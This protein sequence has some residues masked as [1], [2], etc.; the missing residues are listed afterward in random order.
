MTK[1]VSRRALPGIRV[2]LFRAFLDG[3]RHGIEVGA[4][5]R[6]REMNEAVARHSDRNAQ[7]ACEIQDL[8]L[9]GNVEAVHFLDNLVFNRFAHD[10]FNLGNDMAYVKAGLL[11][12]RLL[13]PT[14]S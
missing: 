5:N 3:L 14:D 1:L 7:L 4:I 12:S 6:A 9:P 13:E 11:T 8:P 2:D 10:E